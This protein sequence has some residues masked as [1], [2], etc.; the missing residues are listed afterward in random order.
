M[1]QRVLA[2]RFRE[3]ALQS[4]NDLSFT[5]PGWA[6]DQCDVGC[7]DGDTQGLLLAL[8]GRPFETRLGVRC[9]PIELTS[10]SNW[11]CYALQEITQLW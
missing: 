5:C 2:Q 8:G 9:E 3:S 4:S 1:L 11:R 10:P 6:D 7:I